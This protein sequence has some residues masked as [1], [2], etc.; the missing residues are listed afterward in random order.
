MKSFC[1]LVPLLWQFSYCPP[2]ELHSYSSQ[3]QLRGPGQCHAGNVLP[4]PQVEPLPAGSPLWLAGG[5]HR[6]P[7]LPWS[8]HSLVAFK[9][10]MS[11]SEPE[12]HQ[13]LQATV[14]LS[15]HCLSLPAWH[16]H[17]LQASSRLQP[18]CPGH[19]P[20]P[21]FKAPQCWP[22]QPPRKQPSPG[23]QCHPTEPCA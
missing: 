11:S 1:A 8:R 3:E 16:C 14:P 6:R 5:Q 12:P 10:P 19:L 2:R 17:S 21:V 13:D 15:L 20:L 18:A 23:G 22:L 4:A 7:H 9:Y